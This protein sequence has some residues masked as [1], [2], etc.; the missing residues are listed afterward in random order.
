MS[1]NVLTR[2]FTIIKLHVDFITKDCK[3]HYKVGQLKVGLVLQTG[4]GITK[5]DNFYL[6][7]ILF[8][9]FYFNKTNERNGGRVIDFGNLLLYLPNTLL[10]RILE[11]LKLCYNQ[12]KEEITTHTIDVAA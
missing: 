2:K 9:G 3:R 1:Q 4:T 7:F 12:K 8:K 11:K 10:F 6:K 5:Q